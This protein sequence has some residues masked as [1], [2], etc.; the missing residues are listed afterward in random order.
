MPTIAI[1]QTG[2]KQYIVKE[3]AMLKVEKLAGKQ[4]DT[5]IFDQVLLAGEYN[6]ELKIGAPI[7]QG[8]K[9]EASIIEQGRSEKVTIIKFKNKIRYRRKRGHRQPYTK[10]KINK[11]S[12]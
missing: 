4:G 8:A 3:G 2:G 11:I 7:A 1:I 5:I 6:G 12:A 10:V 9:V